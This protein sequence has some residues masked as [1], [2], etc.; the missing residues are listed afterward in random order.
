MNLH[1]HIEIINKYSPWFDR[2]VFYLSVDENSPYNTTVGFLRAFDNDT[3]DNFGR[4]V[5]ELRNGQE[6]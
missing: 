6:R 2:E 1:I 4:V 3:F 5:Y